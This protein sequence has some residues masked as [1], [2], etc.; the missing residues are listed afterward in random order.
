MEKDVLSRLISII[1]EKPFSKKKFFMLAICG[2]YKKKNT[3]LFKMEE[4]RR[5]LKFDND[6]NKF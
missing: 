5:D 1:D 3:N 6:N 4:K 2:N